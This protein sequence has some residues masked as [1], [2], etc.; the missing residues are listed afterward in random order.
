MLDEKE[1]SYEY[2]EYKKDPLDEGEIRDVLRKLD[3]PASAV[4]RKADRVNRELGLTGEEEEALLVSKMA[5][6]PT[7]L[8]RPIAVLGE[9]AALGR[10]VE[11]IL[12]ILS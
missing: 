11:R 4:L 12:E 9:K 1:I 3:L 5:E 8:Q 10:P 7:L 2:R 6:Y